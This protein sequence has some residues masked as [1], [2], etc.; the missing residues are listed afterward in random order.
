MRERS[1]F[2]ILV[3]AACLVLEAAVA[4]RVV[5]QGFFRRHETGF[6]INKSKAVADKVVKRF[7]SNKPFKDAELPV[8]VAVQLLE[9]KVAADVTDRQ[10]TDRVLNAMLAVPGRVFVVNQEP[11]IDNKTDFRLVSYDDT[12]R[13]RKRGQLMGADYYVSGSLKEVGG[14]TDKGKLYREYETTLELKDIE[15]DELI[16]KTTVVSHRRTISKPKA[17]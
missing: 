1:V 15:T 16:Q 13:T 9:Q 5:G 14:A 3:F 6:S 8:L 12:W 2:F 4:A 7:L 17:N 11:V 10:F